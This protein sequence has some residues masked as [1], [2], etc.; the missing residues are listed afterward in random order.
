MLYIGVH[1]SEYKKDASQLAG[2]NGSRQK[3]SLD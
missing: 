1:F 3:L 2:F